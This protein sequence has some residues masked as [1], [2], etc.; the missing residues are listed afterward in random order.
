ME[1]RTVGFVGV[2]NIGTPIVLSLLR[3]GLGVMV[4]DLNKD[5]AAECL[6]AGASFAESNAE[7]TATCDTIGVA[8]VNDKQLNGLFRSPGGLLEVAR[9]GTTFIVHSTVMPETILALGEETDARGLKLVDAQVSGGDLRAREGDLA[10]MCGGDPK[11]LEVNADYFDAIS[12]RTEHMGPRGAGAGA[13]LAIQMMTFGN[14]MAAIESMRLAR[15][16]GLEE[17]KLADFAT[18]TTAD[19]WVAQMWGNYDR[20]LHNHPLS[21]TDALFRMFDKD[22]FN[23]VVVGREAGIELPLTATSSQLMKAAMQE[24]LDFSA[25]T[26]APAPQKR[27]A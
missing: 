20:L 22:L 24:R 21:G 26:Y 15:A 16:L 27:S 7:L 10:I 5:Q 14:W 17:K 1:K 23:S 8:V 18:D 25:A 6:G 4:R 19:S 12:R 3:A 11:D 2:G 9:P 13:K